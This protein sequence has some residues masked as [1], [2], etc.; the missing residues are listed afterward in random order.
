MSKVIIDLTGTGGLADR[1]FGNYPYDSVDFQRNYTAKETEYVSGVVNPIAIYGHLSPANNTFRTVTMGSADTIRSM[2]ADQLTSTIYLGGTGG[3]IQ[4]MQDG[5]DDLAVNG[6]HTV[7]GGN[8][9]DFETYVVNGVR[10]LFYTYRKSGAGNMGMHDFGLTYSDTFLSGSASGGFSLGAS[11]NHVLI[12]ADNG[13]LYIL[14]GSALHKYDGNTGPTYGTATMN[15]LLWPPF[16]QLIDGV[17]HRGKIW[18]SMMKSTRDLVAGDNVAI[19][20]EYCGVYVWDRQST[21]ISMRDFIPV[22]GVREI[23]NIFVF[24]DS[25]YCFTVSSTR[26]TELR[27]YD[28]SGFSVVKE[29]GPQDYPVYKDSV[30][31]NSRFVTWTSINGNIFY[32]G[33]ITESSDNALYKLGSDS[34][35]GKAM[36]LANTQETAASGQNTSPEAYYMGY[37]TGVKKWYPHAILPASAIQTPHAGNFYT[38]I[39]LLPKLSKIIRFTVFHDKISTLTGT[40]AVADLRLYLNQ[41]TT[42]WG[43]VTITKEDLARGFKHHVVGVSNVNMLQF[44]I[45][46]RTDRGM[47]NAFRPRYIEVEYEETEKKK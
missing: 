2:L 25:I 11:N 35:L 32:Y 17:D 47:V 7:T 39:K 4:E 28:G 15:V 14:D 6:T 30:S 21:I 9:T 8:I 31:V 16:F 12:S 34:N 40:D 10:S 45:T 22:Q 1:F 43:T 37:S 23:R 41:A 27:K 5:F 44:G 19:Y 46:W 3:T 33:K 38:G 24:Q 36:L 26:F 29:L 20:S 13:Y 18:I 42:A